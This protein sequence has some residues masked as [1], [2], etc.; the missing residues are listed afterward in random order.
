MAAVERPWWARWDG[1][2]PI[3]ERSRVR[4]LRP[5]EVWLAR[6]LLSVLFVLGLAGALRGFA[7][8]LALLANGA[9]QVIATPPHQRDQLLGVRRAGE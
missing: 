3:L 7:W 6:V 2:P 9:V 1:V 8:S 4:A 5:S